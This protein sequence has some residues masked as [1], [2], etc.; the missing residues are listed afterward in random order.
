MAVPGRKLSPARLPPVRSVQLTASSKVANSSDS[1]MT[2]GAMAPDAAAER[3]SPSPTTPATATVRTTATAM[4]A[5]G[6]TVMSTSPNGASGTRR[7]LRSPSMANSTKAY[8]ATAPNP[9]WPNDRIP[10]LPM[11]ICI[12]T[13]TVALMSSDVNSRSEAVS[14]TPQT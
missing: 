2:V 14:P 3:T 10:V 7:A 5:A 13:T 9:T 6:C 12:P 11:K 8:P 4:A 1:V